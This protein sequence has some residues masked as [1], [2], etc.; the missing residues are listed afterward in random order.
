MPAPLIR[1][2]STQIPALVVPAPA[3][4]APPPLPPPASQAQPQQPPPEARRRLARA[5]YVTLATLHRD[6]NSNPVDARIE[7]ISE[8]GVL[9]VASEA[10]AQGDVVRLRFATPMS[11][12][13]IE[14]P[15]VARW[16]RSSR[17][18]RAT[19]L[20]FQDL[21]E[22]TRAEIKQYVELM[23]PAKNG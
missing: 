11:G 22:T 18:T 21:T 14:V 23:G 2:S 3:L 9:L 6:A 13:M 1:R 4:A 17:G 7:D 15:A 10:C 19:G 8:G 16:S 5:P 12:R 20:E